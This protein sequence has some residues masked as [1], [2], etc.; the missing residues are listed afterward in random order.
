MNTEYAVM[1][2]NGA[3]QTSPIDAYFCKEAV[4]NNMSVATTAPSAKDFLIDWL[5]GSTY[6]PISHGAGQTEYVN[7]ND[8]ATVFGMYSSF[9]AGSSTASTFQKMSENYNN[10]ANITT[11]Q[12]LAIKPVAAAAQTTLFSTYRPRVSD[13]PS[14]SYSYSTSTNTWT[15]YDK[16]GTRYLY[17]SDD[18]GRMYDVGTGTSTKTYKWVLQEV[19]DTNDNYIKYTYLR[20]GNELYPYQITYTGHGS[21][22]GI[23]TITFA[24]ST[25][26]DTRVSF[27]AGFEASTTKRISE[28]D[29]SANGSTVRKYLLGYGTGNN[30]YRSLLTSVQ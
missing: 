2:I 13:G 7:F 11:L 5:T 6:S 12:M 15:A 8:S 4:S 19:R 24:T 27:A 29:A 18:S 17:G 25:R 9:V 14:N 28:I 26:P 1:T 23:S 21:I 10:G 3:N 22:N 16:N 20:D 30:G